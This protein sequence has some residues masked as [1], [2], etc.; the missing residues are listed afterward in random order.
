MKVCLAHLQLESQEQA[1]QAD[2]EFRLQVKKMEI[3]AAKAVRLR[4]LELDSQRQA[5]VPVDM[6]STSPSLSHKPF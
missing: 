6:P 5:S 3:E 4:Q 1:R 2:R